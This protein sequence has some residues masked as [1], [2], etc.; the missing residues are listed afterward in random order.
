MPGDHQ[1]DEGVA[2]LDPGLQ[3]ERTSLAWHRT[4]LAT[5]LATA[6]LLRLS[7]ETARATFIVACG[8]VIATVAVTTLVVVI[9]PPRARLRS[10]AAGGDHSQVDLGVR[11]AVTATGPVFLGV[12]V[13]VIASYGLIGRGLR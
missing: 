4:G 13:M 6:A 7:F 11:I 1:V 12:V 10:D 5:I 8:A 2:S 9:P 3:V